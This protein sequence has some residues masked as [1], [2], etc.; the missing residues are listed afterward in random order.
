MNKE[1]LKHSLSMQEVI[2]KYGLHTNRAGFISCPFHKGDRAP[3]MKIYP[4]D[5]H[6]YACGANGDIFSFVMG[7]EN[8]DFKTAFKSFGGTYEEKSDYQKKM[9][10]YRLQ[11]RR[12]TQKIKEANR[13]EEQ[14]NTIKEIEQQILFKKL[15]PVMSSDWCEA[16]NRLEYLF[17]KLEV[18]TT[19][20]R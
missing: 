16:V 3:S 5:Y 6:C 10:K 18:L 2:G 11:K 8:C 14:M 12:E 9:Y 13:E 1:E 4:K 20:K 19:E 15:F 17:Y 7:M